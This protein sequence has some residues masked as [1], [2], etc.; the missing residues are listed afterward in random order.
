MLIKIVNKAIRGVA[1]FI[2]ALIVYEVGS[3]IVFTGVGLFAAVLIL[4]PKIFYIIGIILTIGY[5]QISKKETTA[6]HRSAPV[7]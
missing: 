1:W 4:I 3:W 6:R 2:A 7:F 5:F